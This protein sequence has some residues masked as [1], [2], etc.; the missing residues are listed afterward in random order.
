MKQPYNCFE[1]GLPAGRA[2]CGR[3]LPLWTPLAVRLC[4][5]WKFAAA[6]LW[7]YLIIRKTFSSLLMAPNF[8]TRLKSKIPAEF[9]EHRGVGAGGIRGS[10]ET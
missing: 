2:A 8:G 6:D 1:G 3:L 5:A 4:L 9:D 7:S 10:R